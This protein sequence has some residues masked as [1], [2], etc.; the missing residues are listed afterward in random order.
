MAQA[1]TYP[2]KREHW[3]KLYAA[4]SLSERE[5]RLLRDHQPAQVPNGQQ[6]KLDRKE[7]IVAGGK[8]YVGLLASGFK[9]EELDKFVESFPF[10]I[11]FTHPVHARRDFLAQ[12]SQTLPIEMIELLATFELQQRDGLDPRE[13]AIKNKYFEGLQKL[14]QLLKHHGHS[15]SSLASSIAYFPLAK[16]AIGVVNHV[17]AID[18]RVVAQQSI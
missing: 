9:P 12:Y 2:T 14:V 17:T 11:G 13:Q 18:N 7:Y 10:G 4:R 8:L 16:E 15:A 3:L 1:R 6:A 5:Q